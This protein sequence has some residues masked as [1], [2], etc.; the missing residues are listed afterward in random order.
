MFGFNRVLNYFHFRA[1]DKLIKSYIWSN[2]LFGVFSG[3]LYLLY[4]FDLI[5]G[6]MALIVGS[7]ALIVF[8]FLISILSI[9]IGAAIKQCE[10]SLFGLRE[11]LRY[12]FIWY[13]IFSLSFV[14][15]EFSIVA[16][17][18]N[19]LLLLV[20]FIKFK[21]SLGV[22][23][24]TIDRSSYR[25]ST[26]EGEVNTNTQVSN[27]TGAKIAGLVLL[28]VA[29]SAANYGAVY[30]IVINDDRVSEWTGDEYDSDGYD[31]ENEEGIPT[32][33]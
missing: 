22:E 13:G 4:T 5:S 33:L 8:Y 27:I 17:W 14:F 32:S 9:L 28:S 31:D 12:S 30:W 10:H 19:T 11:P 18:L 3:A 26:I 2:S 7:I 23:R 25:A 15:S 29:L 20:L 16:T 24:T 21:R 1:A 6:L